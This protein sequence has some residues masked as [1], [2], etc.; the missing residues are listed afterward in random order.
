MID[1]AVLD[2]WVDGLRQVFMLVVA[3]VA[4]RWRGARGPR[5]N[6]AGAWRR[7]DARAAPSVRVRPAGRTG[8]RPSH[9][10]DRRDG[11]DGRPDIDSRGRSR[12]VYVGSHG[13]GRTPDGPERSGRYRHRRV[14]DEL[15]RGR[16]VWR[17][18]AG[19]CDCRRAP[20]SSA[21]SVHPSCSCWRCSASVVRCRSRQVE[22]ARPCGGRIGLALATVGLDPISGTPR[23]TLGQLTLWDGVGLI[24]ASLGL[25]AIPEIVSLAGR[26]SIASV[27]RTTGST[28]F[29]HGVRAAVERWSVVLRSAR[30]AP[31]WVCFR[32]LARA[33]RSGWRYAQ[34]ARRAPDGAGVRV[35]RGRRRDCPS[36]ANNATLGGALVPMLSLGIPGSLGVG[37]AL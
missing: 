36:A 14:A 18:D 1:S 15:A 16:V 28:G 31:R 22:A 26:S 6:P 4:A 9:R 23:F 32:V 12:R 21:W 25:F 10:R 35:R 29:V 5:R 20:A 17:A 30:L 33:R 3:V 37:H 2:A 24:P 19:R 13:G 11:D 34:A 27:V 7:R 8:V